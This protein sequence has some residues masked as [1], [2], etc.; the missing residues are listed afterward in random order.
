MLGKHKLQNTKWQYLW[1]T[2]TLADTSR[3]TLPHCHTHQTLQRSPLI[4]F[5]TGLARRTIR[6]KLYCIPRA[7]HSSRMEEGIGHGRRCRRAS[8]RYTRDIEDHTAAKSREDGRIGIT[9]VRVTPSSPLS[10]P[11]RLSCEYHRGLT[12]AALYKPDPLP[13]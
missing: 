2:D 10:L 3:V 7:I 6:N 13:G 8:G 5:T 11:P 9:I 1:R 12:P 4:R